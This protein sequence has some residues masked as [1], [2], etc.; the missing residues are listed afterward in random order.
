LLL[1]SLL[2]TGI[3]YFC[4]IPDMIYNVFGGT[5]NL[6]Q[7]NSLFFVSKQNLYT[8]VKTEHGFAYFIVRFLQLLQI[9]CQTYS[10]F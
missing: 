4:S 2:S 10:Y 8:Y 9:L 1:N 6:A 5:L 3:L 7:L